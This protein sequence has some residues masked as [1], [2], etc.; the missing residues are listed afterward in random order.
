MSYVGASANFD[1]GLACSATDPCNTGRAN[2][3]LWLT[4]LLYSSRCMRSLASS[5]RS[6]HRD[7]CHTQMTI[8][9]QI[10]RMAT[11]EDV[12]IWGEPPP[13]HVRSV[14]VAIDRTRVCRR[15]RVN[16]LKTTQWSGLATW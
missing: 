1:C 8:G 13:T 5:T 10:D 14:R 4:S 15:K 2:L 16:D 9:V 11:A 3:G 6:P 7:A 12:Q